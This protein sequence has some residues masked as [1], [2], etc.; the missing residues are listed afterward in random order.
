MTTEPRT[1]AAGA[2][3]AT[4]ELLID[5]VRPNGRILLVDGVPQSYVDLVDP[6]YLHFDYVRRMA[7]VVDAAAARGAALRVLHLGGGGLTLPRY[8]AATRPDSVQ[9]VVERD[10]ALVDLVRRELPLPA[11]DLRV[12]VADARAA[13]EAE[14]DG[15]FDLVL[16]DVYQAAQMPEH[17]ASAEF[18][19]QAARVLRPDGIYLVNLTDLP[20]LAFSRVQAST[21]RVAFADV[22]VIASRAMLRGRRY[23]NVVLAAAREPDRLPVARLVSLAARDRVPGGVLHGASLDRFVA[24]TRPATDATGNRAVT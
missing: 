14:D 24:G 18:A 12:R 22:A 6:T 4:T 16:A 20:L 17:V 8:V 9:V 23:G 10:A 21:L 15:R 19:A 1:P 2:R 7:S 3:T 13:L 11:G 5:R